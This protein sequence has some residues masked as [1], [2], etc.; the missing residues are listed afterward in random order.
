MHIRIADRNRM[1]DSVGRTQTS[2]IPMSS[3]PI[4]CLDVHAYPLSF[5]GRRAIRPSACCCAGRAEHEDLIF[6]WKFG[7]E[8]QIWTPPT[9]PSPQRRSIRDDADRKGK[10]LNRS[11]HELHLHWSGGFLVRGEG[12]RSSSHSRSIL[13][14]SD[15]DGPRRS[16]RQPDVGIA[17]VRSYL[18]VA[19]C[20][21]HLLT[22]VV[23]ITAIS[24][25]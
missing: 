10:N 5:L 25:T 13:L 15:K 8:Q 16:A 6:R 11:A 22:Q 20:A 9:H 23:Y 17:P 4:P 7:G 14:G 3:I 12:K 18:N 21:C 19:S 1:N 2:S 24:R